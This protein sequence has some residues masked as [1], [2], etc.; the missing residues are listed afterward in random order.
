MKK[1]AVFIS[2]TLLIVFSLQVSAQKPEKV[3]IYMKNGNILKG[4]LIYT[5]N[6]NEVRLITYNDN[7]F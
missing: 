1:R 4:K 6:E 7:V 2:I 5:P 3:E